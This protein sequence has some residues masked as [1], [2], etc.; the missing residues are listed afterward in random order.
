MGLYKEK[1]QYLRTHPGSPSG[2]GEFIGFTKCRSVE[3]KEGI[4]IYNRAGKKIGTINRIRIRLI[5]V[6]SVRRI[7]LL[8]RICKKIGSGLIISGLSNS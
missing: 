5:R 8:K 6:K 3:R 2:P 7:C 1:G 4:F